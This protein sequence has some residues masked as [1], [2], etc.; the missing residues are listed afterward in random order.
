MRLLSQKSR[1]YKG[2]SYEKYWVVIPSKVVKELK[3][4]AGKDLKVEVKGKKLVIE[5]D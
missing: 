5:N 2:K 3:W 1:E 4:K